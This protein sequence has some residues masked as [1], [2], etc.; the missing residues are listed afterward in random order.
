MWLGKFIVGML[1]L[2]YGGFFGAVLGVFIGH[3]IDRQ[4]SVLVGRINPGRQ[5]EI[6]QVFFTTVFSLLGKLAKADGRISE[7]EVSHT[8]QLM[9]QMGLTAEHR[10]EA[11]RLFKQGASAD[12]S[13]AAAV[14]A[15][16]DTCGR[17]F[18]LRHMLFNYLVS[19]AIADGALASAEE[20]VLREVA[21]R[22][23]FSSALFNRFIDML[24][25]QSQ[26]RAGG[27]AQGA[28]GQAAG[29]GDLD[30]AYR[31]LGVKASDSDAA[32]KKAYRKLISE[33]HPDKLIGQGVPEDMIKV[34]TERS[35]E[36]QLAYDLIVKHRKNRAA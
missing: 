10:Q 30:T 20:A 23:G 4:F 19:M 31:A 13:I 3:L 14:Q 8:E 34:A 11:I 18:N 24:K 15:F 32:I 26:F 36:I 12:F 6:E 29:I 7:Q 35:Q 2:T 22:L 28:A 25:A 9:A 16:N 21:E 27:G 33:N 5:Q 1:G 17:R